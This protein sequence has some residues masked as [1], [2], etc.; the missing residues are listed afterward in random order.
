MSREEDASLKAK[1]KVGDEA[2]DSTTPTAKTDA[3]DGTGDTTTSGNGATASDG[4]AGTIEKVVG[5]VENVATEGLGIPE[6]E[7][8]ASEDAS[9]KTTGI[10]GI[11]LTKQ[12]IYPAMSVILLVITMYM[13]HYSLSIFSILIV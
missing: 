10:T 11:H 13:Y 7:A 9:A 12:V 6:G 5:K 2:T 4:V 8:S 1:E 3:S